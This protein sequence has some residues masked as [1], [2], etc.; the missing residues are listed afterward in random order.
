[1]PSFGY[2]VVEVILEFAAGE[3]M[4]CAVGRWHI[5]VDAAEV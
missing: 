2:D 3:D 1:V 5:E 4:H